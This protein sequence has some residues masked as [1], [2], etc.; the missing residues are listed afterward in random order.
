MGT[1]K[2]GGTYFQRGQP[3]HRVNINAKWN[4][5]QRTI[6]N[7]AAAKGLILEIIRKARQDL[8]ILFVTKATHTLSKYLLE[9]ILDYKSFEK[10]LRIAEQ[11]EKSKHGTMYTITNLHEIRTVRQEEK[12]EENVEALHRSPNRE[13]GRFR[14]RGGRSIRRN[15]QP[16]FPTSSSSG[17]KCYNCNKNH[18]AP[19]GYKRDASTA[20]VSDVMAQVS[21]K[22]PTLTIETDEAQMGKLPTLNVAMEI[23]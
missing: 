9:H 20:M 22:M 2:K 15:A 18:Q 8:R 23:K 10:A 19:A 17:G 13:R 5:Q 11:W 7:R 6:A 16:T 12:E 21:Q 4:L 1:W 14:R 3:R